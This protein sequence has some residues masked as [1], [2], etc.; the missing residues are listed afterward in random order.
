MAGHPIGANVQTEGFDVGRITES[1][2]YDNDLNLDSSS[3]PVPT[4]TE[5]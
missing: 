1:V 4:I 5:E 3:L 2:R